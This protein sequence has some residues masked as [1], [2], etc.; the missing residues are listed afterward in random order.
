MHANLTDAASSAVRDA[1]CLAQR[2]SAMDD[3]SG[4]LRKAEALSLMTYGDAGDSFRSIGDGAQDNFL[5]AL[6]GLLCTAT[7]ALD[8]LMHLAAQEDTGAVK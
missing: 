6:H 4:A 1:P 7:E 5:W 3:L 2:L 8:R